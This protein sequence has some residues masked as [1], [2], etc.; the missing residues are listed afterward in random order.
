MNPY[1]VLGV[2]EGAT[3]EE[4]RAAYH[5]MVK[6]YHPDQ[7]GNNPLKD[8]ANEKLQEVNEAYET[9]T[10]NVNS[11]SNSGSYTAGNSYSGANASEFSRVRSLLNS[12]N[13]EI[14][15]SVLNSISDRNAEWH[16]LMGVI[17]LRRGSY[18]A[19]REEMRTAT[20][21]D[22]ANA[23]YRN[24]F[25]TLQNSGAAFSRRYRE[26]NGSGCSVCQV[27]STLYCADCCCECFG[28][29]CISCC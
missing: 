15:F 29:D 10:K 11:N 26:N 27:C 28:G 2:R 1:M 19:A 14:A 17:H 3:L 9:L 21:M 23:E 5:T 16:Y 12:G 4:I 8:L 22:P 7:Y 25:A 24:A 6:K 18:D 20:Q 13:I